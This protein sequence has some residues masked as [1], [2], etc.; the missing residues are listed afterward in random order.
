MLNIQ[1]AAHKPANVNPTAKIIVNTPYI[2]DLFGYTKA[3]API[4]VIKEKYKYKYNHNHNSYC[5]SEIYKRKEKE[6]EK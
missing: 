5:R 6:E 3:K 1:T 2:S 4:S